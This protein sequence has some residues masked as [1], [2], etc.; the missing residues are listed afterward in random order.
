MWHDDNDFVII[1]VWVDDMLLFATTDQLKSK[2]IA[3]VENEWEI[4]NIGYPQR[5]LA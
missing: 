5:S 4:S 3:D 1:A 2:A